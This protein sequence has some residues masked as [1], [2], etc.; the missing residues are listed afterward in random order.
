[1]GKKIIERW[2]ND[3]VWKQRW[4]RIAL[5]IFSENEI[6]DTVEDMEYTSNGYLDLRGFPLNVFIAIQEYTN[7]QRNELLQDSGGLISN[8]AKKSAMTC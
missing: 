3:P 8:S 4:E 7:L 2:K 1:M 5:W 6:I